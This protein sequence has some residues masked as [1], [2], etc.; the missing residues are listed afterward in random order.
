M[1]VGV[2]SASIT[3]PVGVP[4]AGYGAR[5]GVSK[6]IHDD[7]Y[8]KAIVFDEGDMKAALIRCDLIGLRRDAVKETREL[9]ESEM[10][11][12]GDNIM[13]TCTHTHSGPITDPI[14]PDLDMWMK[15]LIRK[16]RGTVATAYRN[17]KEAK[18]GVG[19]G[20]VDGIVINRR[21]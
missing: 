4:M 11:I 9:I 12:D 3:P 20:S 13:I 16:M 6:G 15:V 8:A 17:S 2:A 7:L 1:K 18:V 14:Y 19:S 5:K 21:K 10:G